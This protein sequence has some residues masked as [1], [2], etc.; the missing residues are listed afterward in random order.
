MIRDVNILGMTL[1]SRDSVWRNSPKII[2]NPDWSTTMSIENVNA[3]RRLVDGDESL[4]ARLLKTTGIE[5]IVEIATEA[6]CSCT[7]EEVN[8]VFGSDDVELSEFEMKVA[9][10]GGRHGDDQGW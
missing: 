8:Q 6:G 10:G 7:T 2:H 3:F 5:D 1:P 9:A 4:Q